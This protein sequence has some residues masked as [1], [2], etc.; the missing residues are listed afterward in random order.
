MGFGP[1]LP[2]VE[3]GV[4]AV[5]HLI[6]LLYPEHATPRALDLLGHTTRALLA[7]N[8]PL[9]FAALDRFW[10]DGEWRQWVMGRWR[11]PLAGPWDGL[12][13]A[14]LAPDTLDADFGWILADRLS[15]LRESALD[16]EAAESEEPFT[17][18]WDRPENTPPGEDEPEHQ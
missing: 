10:R 17:V 14:G 11:A 4:E 5:T 15:T 2:D 12:G 9:T 1:K 6:S 3:S 13:P 16:E 18:H 8:V 7:A